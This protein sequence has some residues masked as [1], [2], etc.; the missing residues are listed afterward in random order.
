M[1]EIEKQMYRKLS[2]QITYAKFVYL[3]T[4]KIFWKYRFNNR[5]RLMKK[6]IS[7]ITNNSRMRN[8]FV[9]MKFLN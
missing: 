3:C 5:L 1:T 6:F 7:K 4:R 9:R 2:R 8:Q